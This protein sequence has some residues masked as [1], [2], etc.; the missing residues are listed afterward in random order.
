M[1]I[2][3]T[4]PYI[5]VMEEIKRRVSVVDAFQSGVINA[6]YVPTNVES[7]ILQ[8]R[9]IT[10]LIALASLSANKE[11]FE[12]NSMKFEK[13]WKPIDILRDLEK[14]NPSYYPKPIKETAV[15][16]P[17]GIVEHQP[18][19]EGFLTKEDLVELHGRCGD[20]LH[21]KNPFGKQANYR[22]YLDNI[23]IWL[24]KIIKL[25]NCHEIRLLGDEHFHLVHM[26]EEG[27]D[28]IRMYTFALRE[29][30]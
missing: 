29:M 7:M 19:T 21:A 8:I 3:D 5:R 24:S 4:A 30:G 6:I 9:M 13:H 12:S 18:I 17:D 10:E 26:R 27:H 16:S 22:Y 2:T 11:L 28:S 15:N 14:L 23:P 1:M 20:L 25:L